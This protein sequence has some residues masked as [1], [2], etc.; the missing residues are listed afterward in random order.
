MNFTD[1]RAWGWILRHPKASATLLNSEMWRYGDP[2]ATTSPNMG[3]DLFAA[4]A[5]VTAPEGFFPEPVLVF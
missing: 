5:T 3:Y 1:P 2:R 4:G